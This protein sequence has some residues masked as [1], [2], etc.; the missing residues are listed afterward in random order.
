MGDRLRDY[1]DG[2]EDLCV[3]L[4]AADREDIAER[5]HIAKDGGATSGEILSHTGAVIQ[6]LVDDSDAELRE[7]ARRLL[8]EC[9]ALWRGAT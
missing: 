9:D 4:V 1:Y 3:R 6:L 8:S 7:S 2:V 5:L